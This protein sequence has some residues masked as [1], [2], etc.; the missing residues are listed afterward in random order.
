[1]NKWSPVVQKFKEGPRDTHMKINVIA[2]CWN[3]EKML[4]F[5]LEHYSSFCDSI[6]LY[7]GGS[8]D[9][10][11]EIIA[12][13]PKAKVIPSYNG[14]DCLFEME[15]VRIRNEEYKQYAGDYDWQIVCDIDEFFYHPDII[16]LL[17][18]YKAQGITIPL[19]DGYE[20]Y[21]NEY[22]AEGCNLIKTIQTG[23]KSE[24]YSK[25]CIFN[26]RCVDIRFAPGS[27]AS[28]PL[29]DVKYSMLPELKLLHYKFLGWEYLIERST[30]YD[31]RAS[32][33]D[34]GHHMSVHFAKYMKITQE[35]FAR[36]VSDCAKVI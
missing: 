15:L 14:G 33:S 11:L 2:C 16:N 17:G 28:S 3:E 36:M 5:F 35:N 22:P 1:M 4:P 23:K 12:G 24:L 19:V 34:K 10:T 25:K 30:L 20:M 18:Q 31:K 6:I 29:G 21:S 13:Y 26:P 8:T 32:K 9:R 27:H 7:D